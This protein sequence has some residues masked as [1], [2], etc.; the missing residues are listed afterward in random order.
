[1]ASAIRRHLQDWLTAI[2]TRGRPVAVIEEGHISTATC[3]LANLALR[4]N[5]TL[6]WDAQQQRVVGDDEANRLLRRPYRQP[7]VH[8]QA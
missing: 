4:L 7:W 3:I 1:V 8:P 6:A 5:R 2:R